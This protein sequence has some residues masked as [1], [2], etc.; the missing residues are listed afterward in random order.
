MPV[1]GEEKTMS[2]ARSAPPPLMLMFL[3]GSLT[4]AGCGGS[5]STSPGNGAAES[6]TVAILVPAD[7]AVVFGAVT[8]T[9]T[10]AH[11]DRVRFFAAGS[12][13]GYVAEPP[14]TVVWNSG[15]VANGGH[16]LA[17]RAEQGT[18]SAIAEI[19]VLV[20]NVAG[21]VIV[22]VTPSAA[23]VALGATQQFA[24]QVTGAAS[25][26][27]T[28]SV[29]GGATFGAISAAGLYTAPSVLPTPA[30][31]A[32][33]ATSVAD[34]TSSGTATVSLVPGQTVPNERSMILT[35]FA[36]AYDV[37]SLGQEGV[38][39]L[40]EAVFGASELNGGAL[41]LTGT[42][43]QVGQGS[44]VWTYGA[45]PTDRLL[46]A[47]AGGPTITLVVAG[48]DGYFGGTWED[49]LD[50]HAADFTVAM[51]GAYDLRIQSQKRFTKSN[52]ARGTQSWN[53]EFTRVITGT[54][55]Q[56]QETLTLNVTHSGREI[57][58]YVEPPYAR[59][60][61]DEGYT[62]TIASPSASIVLNQRYWATL[63]HDS[64]VGRHFKSVELQNSS[65]ATLGGATYQWQDV[66]VRW[67]AGSL[68][69]DPGAI[70]VVIEPY[71]WVLAGRL[72]KNGAV[73][74]ELQY[75]GP[76]AEDTHGPDLVLRLT[77]GE[78]IW[79]HT[80]IQYP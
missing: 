64:N 20:E 66:L 59:Y 50:R 53:A 72:L 11:A 14:Y 42:L 19:T 10:A 15:L 36:G 69:N 23:T 61:Y 48:I 31:A 78:S 17:A 25:D 63:M 49:F 3:L 22:T 16:T 1:T 45:T 71:D 60:E 47:F 2:H 39:L 54:C 56:A 7:N 5:D 29:D 52:G 24:A 68:I 41:T 77:S 12:E 8:I 9:A 6:P 70:N 27:V 28:W 73:H 21:A 40:A 57:D 55:V 46:V 13:I 18:R 67:H 44:E 51:A 35:A 76:L 4:L 74:G 34:P 75:D 32:V 38:A 37:G 43:T 26:A 80:L 58:C 65:S 30:T 62:G 79:V 33:R